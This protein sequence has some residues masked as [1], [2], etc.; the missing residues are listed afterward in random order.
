M[1]QIIEKLI[2]DIYDVFH[3]DRITDSSEFIL[4]EKVRIPSKTNMFD[5]EGFER[6]RL[7]SV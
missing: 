6:F 3:M 7:C 5:G 4:V 1:Q 2:A